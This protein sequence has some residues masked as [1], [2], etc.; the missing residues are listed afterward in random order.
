MTRKTGR[1]GELTTELKNTHDNKSDP[2]IQETEKGKKEENVYKGKK[3]G[4][5]F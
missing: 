3:G 5:C 2:Y 4:Y 1:E